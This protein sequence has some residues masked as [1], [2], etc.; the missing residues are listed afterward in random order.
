MTLF[1]SKSPL[2][3]ITSG[4]SAL[5]PKLNTA[6]CEAK[7]F[8]RLRRA[9]DAGADADSCDMHP[10]SPRPH[11]IPSGYRG[12]YKLKLGENN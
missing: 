8:E 10:I 1:S 2:S 11:E 6:S 7:P 12:W 4:L 9:S 3:I 5:A